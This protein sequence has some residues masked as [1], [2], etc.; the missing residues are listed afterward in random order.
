MS[1]PCPLRGYSQNGDTPNFVKRFAY[2]AAF[3]VPIGNRNPQLVMPW[4]DLATDSLS[5]LA[6][7]SQAAR[8]WALFLDID[9]TL[10]DIAERPNLVQVPR[11]LVRD[12]ERVSGCLEGALA[13]V[14]GRAIAWIDHAFSPLRLPIAGQQGAEIRL[15][16]DAP[17]VVGPTVDL[18]ALRAH[19]RPLAKVEGIEIEDKGLSLAVH[20]RRAR[21]HAAAQL[22][23]VNALAN[24]GENL[25]AVPGR[26]VYEVKARATS[27]GTAVARLAETRSFSGRMPVYF[28][29]DHTDEYAFRE[30]LARGGI[31]VQV[32]PSPAPPGCLW[33][34][35]PRETRR[36]L[37]GLFARTAEVADA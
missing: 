2:V 18:E 17:V 7:L 20:Y 12:L 14:S 31:A 9:G 22:L 24:L 28:G 6:R 23:I 36:W 27:K 26:M 8:H 33:V 19:V 32:G 25:E 16:A 30:V 3:A 35:S 21:D 29:D 15:A 10:L 4:T 1:V 11:A 34:E 13:L 5:R 37:A